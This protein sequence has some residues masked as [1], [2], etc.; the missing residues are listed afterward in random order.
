MGS[1]DASPG[2]TWSR[3]LSNPN[4]GGRRGSNAGQRR[5]SQDLIAG[6]MG[7]DTGG[8]VSVKQKALARVEALKKQLAEGRMGPREFDAE[9]SKV[10]ELARDLAADA[11]ADGFT[12]SEARR[13]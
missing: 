5:M 11:A 13:A 9:F 4:V 3:R 10:W 2:G 8:E 12:T 1:R 6:L 7:D